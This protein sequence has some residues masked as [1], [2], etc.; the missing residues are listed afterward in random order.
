MAGFVLPGQTPTQ[1]SDVARRQQTA[2]TR[3]STVGDRG[4]TGPAQYGGFGLGTTPQG[5]Q[6]SNVP[7]GAAETAATATRQAGGPTNY[8]VDPYGNVV[9]Q[10]STGD[11]KVLAEQERLRLESQYGAESDTRRAQLQ[12]DA[13]AR[14]L[15][16][17]SKLSG[18][19]PG[20]GVTHPSEEAGAQSSRDAIFARA[21]DKASQ[22]ARGS[23]NALRNVM[24]ERGT[25]GSSIEGLRS[26]GIIGGAGSE[27]GDVNR[28]QLIQ[29]LNRQAEVQDLTYGG[30]I[31]QRGQDIAARQPLLGLISA[32]GLY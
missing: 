20:G 24:S 13:E 26:A 14:R 8:Q 29:D 1:R 3:A 5:I 7:Y 17:L 22:I 2:R 23:L 28:E 10:G 25:S 27:L 30:R 19:E 12:A 32:R 9:Y 15:G 6:P 4:S 21:K 31:Q 18:G 11:P 16:Y